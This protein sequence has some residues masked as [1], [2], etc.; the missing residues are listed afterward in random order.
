MNNKDMLRCNILLDLSGDIMHMIGEY[1]QASQ[2]ARLRA[3]GEGE[4]DSRFGEANRPHGS[5]R[6]ADSLGSGVLHRG[7]Q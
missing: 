3:L 1:L 5:K 2:T 7:Q 4:G 6:W